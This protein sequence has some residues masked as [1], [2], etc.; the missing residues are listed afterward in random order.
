MRIVQDDLRG[1]MF[2]GQRQLPDQE[3]RNFLGQQKIAFIGTTDVVAN[4]YVV[5][6]S[7]IYVSGDELWFH[8]G[9]HEGH[10]FHN[11]VANARICLTVAGIGSLTP[12]KDGFACD[13][14]L[15]YSSVVVFGTAKV[16]VDR[17]KKI[18]FFDRM[19]EKYGD[20]SLTFKPGYQM[21]DRIILFRMAIEI[22]TGK[23]NTGMAH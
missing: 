14:S 11:I 4:P 8:T 6:M 18:W 20:P 21:V 2:R 9:P 22:L 1:K 19:V 3:A 13:S 16:I 7:F 15:L 5:P 23:Q 10:M 17:D 12:V